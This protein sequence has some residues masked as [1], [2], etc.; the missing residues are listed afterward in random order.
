MK[1]VVVGLGAPGKPTV[2]VIGMVER[3][4]VKD[5]TT[6][7]T[8]LV[9]V[10]PF[11]VETSVTVDVVPA[12]GET[13][14]DTAPGK[15]T[16]ETELIVVV[17]AGIVTTERLLAVTVWAGNVTVERMVLPSMVLTTGG[18]VT[19]CPGRVI[20]EGGEPTVTVDAGRVTGGTT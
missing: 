4:V 10:T 20:V 13:T 18:N 6:D 8:T 1:V 12:T 3:I 9:V 14:V 19:V 7:K 2:L 16:V 5:G 17:E 15:D 11:A